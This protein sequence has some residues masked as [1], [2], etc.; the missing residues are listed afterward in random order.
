MSRV[1]NRPFTHTHIRAG[2]GSVPDSN[3]LAERFRTGS[4]RLRRKHL[5]ILLASQREL[6]FGLKN[7]CC[8]NDDVTLKKKY[9]ASKILIIAYRT[10]GKKNSKGAF[11]N[12]FMEHI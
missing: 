1:R 2:S 5:K 9:S 10:F 11:F 3:G 7:V 12:N 4:D 8:I 6:G